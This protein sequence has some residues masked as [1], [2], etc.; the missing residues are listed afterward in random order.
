MRLIKVSAEGVP[1]EVLLE[2]FGLL[3][4]TYNRFHRENA[5]RRVIDPPS[6]SRPWLPAGLQLVCR[7]WRDL[8]RPLFYRDQVA[9]DCRNPFFLAKL[10][11]LA[12]TLEIDDAL[13]FPRLLVLFSDEKPDTDQVR[14]VQNAN[15][16]STPIKVIASTS[17]WNSFDSGV[18]GMSSCIVVPRDDCAFGSGG[19]PTLY[20]TFIPIQIT[21][22]N[23]LGGGHRVIRDLV[24]R[25]SHPHN[26]TPVLA[27]ILRQMDLIVYLPRLRFDLPFVLPTAVL[28]PAALTLAG[29]L[30]HPSHEVGRAFL[31]SRDNTV[32]RISFGTYSEA[33]AT[34]LRARIESLGDLNVVVQVDVLEP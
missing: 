30:K 22:Q 16:A 32:K 17:S 7:R 13:P 28:D 19:S 25:F 34:A 5:L 3:Q 8:A 21:L 14:R 18:L 11:K 26:V 4:D 1:D 10:A 27:D 29:I 31:L 6:G 23:N 20:H 15:K 2:I 24:L 9:V 33:D 12:R